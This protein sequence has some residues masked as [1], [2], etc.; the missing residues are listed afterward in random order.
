M[1][2]IYE[3]QKQIDKLMGFGD[4]WLLEYVGTN[5]NKVI[6]DDDGRVRIIL[7]V[8][9]T[10]EPYRDYIDESLTGDPNL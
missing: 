10:L 7:N 6:C 9:I 8:V 5:V 4:G 3:I 2:I 1:T